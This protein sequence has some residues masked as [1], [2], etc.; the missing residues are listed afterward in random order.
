MQNFFDAFNAARKRA[1]EAVWHV[2]NVASGLRTVDRDGNSILDGLV[3]VRDDGTLPPDVEVG[4]IIVGL[5]GEF[6]V[7]T[8][9]ADGQRV[10]ELATDYN[11]WYWTARIQF[12]ALM[13]HTT[14]TAAPDAPHYALDDTELPLEYVFP[15]GRT[16]T[17]VLEAVDTESTDVLKAISGQ[18]DPSDRP[19]KKQR[20]W[21]K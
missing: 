11:I 14:V 10:T 6:R 9:D 5:D 7:V 19:S 21:T 18:D 4:E 15:S 2:Y 13:K 16:S 12:N 3:R 20:I 1:R 8:N 17:D